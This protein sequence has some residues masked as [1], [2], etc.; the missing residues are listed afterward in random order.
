M[1]AL[2][3]VIGLTFLA[4]TVF[5]GLKYNKLKK[6]MA[7]VVPEDRGN[8]FD[9]D[10]VQNGGRDSLNGEIGISSALLSGDKKKVPNST[11]ESERSFSESKPAVEQEDRVFN[12]HG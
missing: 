2:L 3:L 5:C 11:S 4:L 7:P 9:D 6:S 12:L 1:F 10:R 8:D